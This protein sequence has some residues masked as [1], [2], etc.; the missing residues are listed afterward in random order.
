[1]KQDNYTLNGIHSRT[2]RQLLAGYVSF[3]S[4]SSL[5]GDTLILVGSLR[6]KAIKLHKIMVVFIQYL[7]VAD[8]IVVLSSILPGAVSLAGNRWI[9]GDLFCYFDYIAYS[10]TAHTIS[11]L[12]GVLALSKFLIVKYPLRAIHF[13]RK[14]AH[15]TG[16]SMWVYSLIFPIAAILKDED[17]VSFSYI[18]YNCLYES[19]KAWTHTAT[20][21]Y[22]IVV[23]LSVFASSAVSCVSSFMLLLLARRVSE[24]VPG[25]LQWQGVI[26]VL[27]AVT[28]HIC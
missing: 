18:I 5:I 23:G 9:L 2:D 21:V 27:A 1:M 10:S 13:S 14:A 28:F 15:L 7:A 22:D 16:C 6:Y 26:M 8:L 3:I 20:A 4:I 12:M 24:R 11:L 25:G 17:C 19:G